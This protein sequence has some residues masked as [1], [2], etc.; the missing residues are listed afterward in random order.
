VPASAGAVPGPE[1]VLDVV[2]RARHH[3]DSYPGCALPLRVASASALRLPRLVWLPWHSLEQKL[4]SGISVVVGRRAP[5]NASSL[6]SW[7]RST[8]QFTQYRGVGIGHSAHAAAGATCDA[9]AFSKTSSGARWPSRR[10][11]I[12]RPS[13]T[14][15]HLGTCHAGQVGPGR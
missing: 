11:Q 15:A 4:R 8:W 7:S 6:G 10:R 5:D 3:S 13:A 14:I 12:E 9:E 2:V 1:T